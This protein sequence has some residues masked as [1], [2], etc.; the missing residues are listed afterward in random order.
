MK[1]K[2]RISIY[3]AIIL[4][5]FPITSSINFVS[6][7]DEK[8]VEINNGE[9]AI[10]VTGNDNVPQYSFWSPNANDSKYQVKFNRL[11]EAI[12]ENGNGLYDKGEDSKVPSSSE[13]LSSLKWNFS[14][15]ETENNKSTFNITSYDGE[16][17]IQ[18]INHLD[19]SKSELKFDIVIQNYTFLS[20]S[21]DAILVLGFHLLSNNKQASQNGN[22]VNFGS[23]AYFKS[24]SNATVGNETLSVQMSEADEEGSPMAFLAFEKFEGNLFYDPTIGLMTTSSIPGYSTLGIYGMSMIGI[25]FVYLRMKFHKRN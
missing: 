12:D 7:N 17:M 8:A 3:V 11:F 20:D 21:E 25:I 18:F 5:L 15:I 19:S 9:L 14:S 10:K 6:G 16:Y 22:T 4:A 23:N 13:S 1:S 2:Y 24:E